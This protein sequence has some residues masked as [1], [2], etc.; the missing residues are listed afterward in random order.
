M[1]VAVVDVFRRRPAGKVCT[2]DL[3][4]MVGRDRQRREHSDCLHGGEF[5]DASSDRIL[6]LVQRARDELD[7][8]VVRLGLEVRRVVPPDR[9][10][11]ECRCLDAAFGSRA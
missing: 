11:A 9:R 2:R 7:D 4:A 8:R 10:R 6:R 5:A 1:L 3:R